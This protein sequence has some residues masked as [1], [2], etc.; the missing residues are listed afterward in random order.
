[1]QCL[2]FFGFHHISA[3]GFLHR[4]GGQGPTFVPPHITEAMLNSLKLQAIDSVLILE[5]ILKELNGKKM[6][7][8]T[9]ST[10]VR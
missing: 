9:I 2:L 5:N 1:M 3:Y 7:M 6:I 8:P 10:F 4:P